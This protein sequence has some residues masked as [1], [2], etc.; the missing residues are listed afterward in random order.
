[1]D[2]FSVVIV[3][4]SCMVYQYVRIDVHDQCRCVVGQARFRETLPGGRERCT[5]PTY[6]MKHG[7]AQADTQMSGR[8]HNTKRRRGGCRERLRGLQRS[9]PQSYQRQ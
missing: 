2:A 6:D 1:M 7:V 3:A 9:Y 5:V 8:T 4:Q